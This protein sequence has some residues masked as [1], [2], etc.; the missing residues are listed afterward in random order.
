[1]TLNDD[2]IMT[3]S[4][5][6]Y[7]YIIPTDIDSVF[8]YYN[9]NTTENANNDGIV[10][11]IMFRKVLD[12]ELNVLYGRYAGVDDL[13]N[14]LI[15]LPYIIK[16]FEGNVLDSADEIAA[17]SFTWYEDSSKTIPTGPLTRA[18]ALTEYGTPVNADAD[19]YFVVIS[20]NSDY[21]IIREDVEKPF[22]INKANITITVKDNASVQYRRIESISWEDLLTVNGLCGVDITAYA[23]IG[24]TLFGTSGTDWEIGLRNSN[25]QDVVVNNDIPVGVYT[26]Y[27]KTQFAL[28]N[29]IV[30]FVTSQ[31]QVT[32]YE[33]SAIIYSA[34][35]TYGED[36][37]IFA[38]GILKEA[39]EDVSITPD[40]VFI[41]SAVTVLESGTYYIFTPKTQWIKRLAGENAGTYTFTTSI[42]DFAVAD[43]GNYTVSIDLTSEPTFTIAK[44]TI[45]AIPNGNQEALDTA[46]AVRYG[47]SSADAKYF[48]SEYVTG[49]LGVS[50]VLYDSNVDGNYTL[51]RYE[52][53]IGTLT[54]IN[55]DNIQVV[56]DAVPV[57]Y[58]IKVYSGSNAL[59][60]VTQVASFELTYGEVGTPTF[61]WNTTDYTTEDLPAGYTITWTVDASGISDLSTVGNYTLPVSNAQAIDGSSNPDADYDV[62]IASIVVTIVPKEI[63]VT[64]SVT[65]ASRVYGYLD[66]DATNGLEISYTASINGII[67][68]G[69][70][71]RGVYNTLTG[72][73]IAKGSRYDPASNELGNTTFN[74]APAYY[75]LTIGNDFVLNN[76]NYK[77]VF[78]DTYESIRFVIE[79]RKIV[80]ISDADFYGVNKDYDGTTTVIYNA[81]DISVNITDKLARTSDAVSVAFEAVYDSAQIGNRT[82]TFSA[83]ALTGDD[84]GNYVLYFGDAST[85]YV[86]QTVVITTLHPGAGAPQIQIVK[87]VTKIHISKS[88]IV[89][90]KQ[91]DG[92]TTMRAADVSLGVSNPLNAYIS[93]VVQSAYP[94]SAVSN[95][96]ITDVTIVLDY[97]ETIDSLGES[98]IIVDKGIE[99]TAGNGT[100]TLK[101]TDMPV[102]ITKRVITIDSFASAVG[103]DKCYDTTDLVD[104]NVTLKDGVLVSGDYVSDVGL[105]FTAHAAK[106]LKTNPGVGLYDRSVVYQGVP[107]YFKFVYN[108]VDAQNVNVFIDSATTS[109][110][111]NYV[112]N[113]TSD[114]W[115]EFCAKNEDTLKVTINKAELEPTLTIAARQYNGDVAVASSLV[116]ESTT[117]TSS[118]S[119]KFIV[120]SAYDRTHIQLIYDELANISYEFANLHILL[121][122]D[123]AKYPYVAFDENGLI[124]RHAVSFENFVITNVGSLG[125]DEVNVILSNYTLY[126]TFYTVSDTGTTAVVADKPQLALGT[127]IGAD[128][129][130]NA[131]GGLGYESTITMLINKKNVV[132]RPVSVSVENKVYD[133]TTTGVAAINDPT[134]IGVVADDAAHIDISLTAVYSQRDVGNEIRVDINNV[135]LTNKLGSEIDYVS[136]Y[137]V[138]NTAVYTNRAITPSYATINFDLAKKTYDGTNTIALSAIKPVISV[139]YDRDKNNYSVNYSFG[140]LGGANVAVEGVDTSSDTATIYGVKLVSSRTEVNYNLYLKKAVDFDIFN[141]AGEF[142][143]EYIAFVNESL[144]GVLDTSIL[145]L[146]GTIVDAAK[147][148]S[149]VNLNDYA[150][151]KFYYNRTNDNR[152]AYVTLPV[153]TIKTFKYTDYVAGRVTIDDTSK[154]IGEYVSN[155]IRYVAVREDAILSTSGSGSYDEREYT[156][157]PIEKQYDHFVGPADLTFKISSELNNFQKQYDGT[158][159]INGAVMVGRTTERAG[160]EGLPYNS[161]SGK[162]GSYTIT[163][164]IPLDDAQK[165]KIV[166]LAEYK[167]ASA[168]VQNIEFRILNDAE[169]PEYILDD[170]NYSS[171][172]TT[173]TV[174]G[175]ISRAVI[176]AYLEDNTVPYGTMIK[177]RVDHVRYSTNASFSIS[178]P[179]P[180]VNTFATDNIDLYVIDGVLGYFKDTNVNTSGV[181]YYTY[182]AVFTEATDFELGEDYH[183]YS[184]ISEEYH[185]VSSIDPGETYYI[186]RSVEMVECEY[187]NAGTNYIFVPVQG[188]MNLPKVFTKVT[189]ATPVG[190]GKA[191]LL[192]GDATNYKFELHHEHGDESNLEVT[193]LTV[194]VYAEDVYVDEEGS[195]VNYAANLS[196]K[197]TGTIPQFSLGFAQSTTSQLSGFVNGQTASELVRKGDLTMPTTEVRLSDGTNPGTAALTMAELSTVTDQLPAGQFYYIYINLSTATATNYVFELKSGDVFDATKI[198]KLLVE[199]PDITNYSVVNTT[200]TYNGQPINVDY[201]GEGGTVTY[202]YYNNSE[203]TG[204]PVTSVTNAGEYY[205]KVKVTK[206]G[207]KDWYGYATLKIKKAAF[208]ITIPAIDVDY[209][210]LTKSATVRLSA[211]APSASDISI[212]YQKGSQ[213]VGTPR[214]V[215]VYTVIAKYTAD[216]DL[217]NFAGGSYAY[218]FMSAST[219]GALVIHGAVI[220]VI[221]SEEDK[222]TII[223]TEGDTAELNYKL[224]VDEKYYDMLSNAGWDY[225]DLNAIVENGGILI[226]YYNAESFNVDDSLDEITEMGVYNYVFEVGY[227][228]NIIL[229]GDISGSFIVGTN[230]LDNENNKQRTI[231]NSVGNTIL[232]ADTQ[233]VYEN[234]VYTTKINSGA[235]SAQY[236]AIKA[237][238]TLYTQ[239]ESN[240]PSLAEKFYETATLKGILKVQMRMGDVNGESTL[241]Q[242]NGKVKVTVIV[243]SSYELDE[244]TFIYKV[245]ENGTL[246]KVDYTVNGKYVTYETDYVNTI[247]FVRVNTFMEWLTENWW[248]AAAAG[249]GVLV[250]LVI[251]IA[252]SAAAG[253][254]KRKAKKL[255]A[256]TAGQTPDNPLEAEIEDA[257]MQDTSAPAPEAS[258][259]QAPPVEESPVAPPPP[260][261]EPP[262]ETPPV[263]EP[264]MVEEPPVETP[265]PVVEEPAPAPAPEAPA[266]EVPPVEEPAPAP[267]TPAPEAPAPEA[268]T[269]APEAPKKAPPPGAVGQKPSAAPKKAPPPGAVGQKPAA[270]PKKAPPPGAVGTKPTTAAPK[271]APPPGA[272]GKK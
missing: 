141:N 42:S 257:P 41:S 238:N 67:E 194:Y 232:N 22:T 266:P 54:A 84:A 148:N 166:F 267:E 82:I 24:L 154:I 111:S 265:P 83:L 49:A 97:E 162:W 118:I 250:L 5:P 246:E 216:E 93:A 243:P 117:I 108:V 213:V 65:K 113:I 261:E 147:Y 136:N 115:A 103:V 201:I 4:S 6:T 69:S 220:D 178:K 190:I 77:V 209:D 227:G 255:A 240:V 23:N 176:N 206:A 202:E 151:T 12:V 62:A 185:A 251:I 46:G 100:V 242:P 112:C 200:K 40:D 181:K 260:V 174:V 33:I 192:G 90:S 127:F 99:K 224:S 146:D 140:F 66:T 74:G 9:T 163:F 132:V 126:G 195:A 159:K 55:T 58:T 183:F 208:K 155:T 199:Y 18:Q 94:A 110:A 87:A 35:K 25:A 10:F 233:L 63:V 252:P 128:V 71:V 263:E 72:S 57:Y 214:D 149:Y 222:N 248:L 219:N 1:M 17:L 39:F 64:P 29:Y 11:E 225:E 3:Y 107:S 38:F 168:G 173:V 180:L 92:T 31:I 47:F 256:Q 27:L 245:T 142:T 231:I 85:P 120:K 153:T 61:V 34:N 165:E 158:K 244:Q 170:P 226:K 119:S 205:A 122:K 207:F 228:A 96:Y 95:N 198:A 236:N 177:D 211:I 88:D 2:I 13:G 143:D 217:T 241:I 21:Y 26:P 139:P 59:I 44:R 68:S 125:D 20:T 186:C 76:Q 121:T 104:V 253:A 50:D 78:A 106:L 189:N 80:L 221:V 191:Q 116:S 172:N 45:T 19:A 137:E 161:L 268:P 156:E 48:T 16:D 223:R 134:T 131:A 160:V 237:N 179:L 197:A 102:Y 15:T 215:G 150:A 210:G 212:T 123:G 239:I 234:V 258:A 91:Y 175:E 193:P 130:D 109:T 157:V 203:M 70:L 184:K 272:V 167:S 133:G 254:K 182:N 152:T 52:I 14:P 196:Y 37:P 169:Y 262:I 75:G 101:I 264:P 79:P 269:P 144:R 171:T 53:T 51:N 230:K 235:T 60:K 164:D 28:E 229:N 86:D 89:I 43:S 56:L 145:E 218:N 135:K 81:G 73:L 7:T 270:A 271:K 114:E 98:N 129:Y 30:T 32:K 247:V 249:A 36:D 204:T 187:D 124:V 259:P 188:S 8:N 105:K 138:T